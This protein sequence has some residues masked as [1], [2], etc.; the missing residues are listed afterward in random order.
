[1]P[2]D[3]HKGFKLQVY[4]SD[5]LNERLNK[6][7]H[8]VNNYLKDMELDDSYFKKMTKTDLVIGALTS[9]LHEHDIN[10]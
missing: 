8:N 6:Y 9:Y 1:M 10:S 3:Y 5:E 4:I 7:L 2:K